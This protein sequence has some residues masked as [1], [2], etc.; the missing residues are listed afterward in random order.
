M[1]R[2]DDQLVTKS[3][4]RVLTRRASCCDAFQANA[5]A[6]P[7]IALSGHED[8]PIA[9][10]GGTGSLRG[11]RSQGRASRWCSPPDCLLPLRTPSERV[12]LRSQGITTGN[13]RRD[14]RCPGRYGGQMRAA[15]I[16]SCARNCPA[17]CRVNFRRQRQPTPLGGG[18]W[19]MCL[20]LQRGLPSDPCSFV[21]SRLF[22]RGSGHVLRI[23][24][25]RRSA[26]RPAN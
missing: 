23:R 19:G 2:Q 13:N 18:N 26:E 24:A 8:A 15:D 6:E 12:L 21:L 17:I 4:C 22:S 9:T 1:F 14:P 5:D 10:G 3:H 25:H 7:A 16:P 20:A 11:K